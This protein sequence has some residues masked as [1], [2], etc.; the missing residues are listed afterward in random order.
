MYNAIGW[1]GALLV[2]IGVFAGAWGLACAGIN[3]WLYFAPPHRPITDVGGTMFILYPG[4]GLGGAT[5][6]I[7]E[8]TL[9]RKFRHAMRLGL[10]WGAPLMLVALLGFCSEISEYRA[11]RLHPELFWTGF[12]LLWTTLLL[13]WAGRLKNLQREVAV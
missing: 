1:R 12:I 4:A 8:L 9:L 10:G 3:C 7:A 2:T 13:L 6:Y 5:G 11:R